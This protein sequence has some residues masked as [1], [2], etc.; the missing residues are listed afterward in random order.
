MMLSVGFKNMR[1]S[2]LDLPNVG[3]IYVRDDYGNPIVVI[4]TE[5]EHATVVTR[6]QEEKFTQ[7]L[8]H[9]GIKDRTD[10]IR[11]DV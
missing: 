8:D 6:A 2:P 3:T 11:I 10:I 5:G 7:V 4:H 1:V 9:L